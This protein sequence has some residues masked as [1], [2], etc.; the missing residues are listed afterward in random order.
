MSLKTKDSLNCPCNG[1]YKCGLH[2]VPKIIW[3]RDSPNYPK[4]VLDK[5]EQIFKDG[6]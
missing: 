3:P 5:F 1:I 6:V 4:D 2:S